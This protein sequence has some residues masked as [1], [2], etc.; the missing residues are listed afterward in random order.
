[1]AN[2][3]TS[4]KSGTNK[5]EK[6][7]KIITQKTKKKSKPDQKQKGKTDPPKTE[8]KTTHQKQKDKTDPPKTEGK[9]NP[10]K[11]ER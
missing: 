5:E 2:P 3:K 1:M 9:T 11:A 6:Q 7:D 10:P 4:E 8:G